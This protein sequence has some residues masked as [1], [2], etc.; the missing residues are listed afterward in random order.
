MLTHIYGIKKNGIGDLMC[1]AEVETQ[2]QGTNVWI[3]RGK[4]RVG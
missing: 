2:M 4:G 3:P 1:K